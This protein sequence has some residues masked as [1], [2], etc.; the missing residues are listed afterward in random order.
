MKCIT[1][2]IC[3][4]KTQNRILLRARVL[5]LFQNISWTILDFVECPPLLRL[6]LLVFLFPFLYM[7]TSVALC[8][9]RIRFYISLF[10]CFDVPL[11]LRL[12]RRFFH[13]LLNVNARCSSNLHASVCVSVCKWMDF[14]SLLFLPSRL[15]QCVRCRKLMITLL[16]SLLA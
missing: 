7:S 6:L 16:V 2:F 13:F 14:K 15:S 5:V 1:R 12:R 11:L 4:S 9:F 8:H 3:R 10:I